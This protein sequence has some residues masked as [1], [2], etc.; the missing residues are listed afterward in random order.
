[1]SAAPSTEI[2]GGDKELSGGDW[3]R[4]SA[5]FALF[6]QFQELLNPD[7][8][9]TA[10]GWPATMPAAMV[11]I[12]IVQEPGRPITKLAQD[13]VTTAGMT[14]IVDKLEKRGLAYRHLDPDDRRQYRIHPTAAGSQAVRD[15]AQFFLTA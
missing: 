5:M 11:L 13:I 4:L 3:N 10:G 12:R 15:L 8:S 7:G 2:P 9:S 14:Q 1:M 6:R